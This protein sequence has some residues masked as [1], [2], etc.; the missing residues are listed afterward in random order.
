MHEFPT[1]PPILKDRKDNRLKGFRNM[2]KCKGCNK[3]TWLPKIF[4]CCKSKT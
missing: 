2:Q 3:K 4:K 1:A